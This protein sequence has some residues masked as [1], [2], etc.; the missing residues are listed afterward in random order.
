MA[1]ASAPA[2]GAAD[3]LALL[4]EAPLPPPVSWMPQTWGWA[5]VGLLLLAALGWLA[6]LLVQRH[7]ANRYRRAAL[8]ELDTI[9]A[10]LGVASAHAAALAALPAL[11]KRTALAFAPR[12][13]V[14]SLSGDDWLRWLDATWRDGHFTRGPGRLLA[15]LAYTQ[16]RATERDVQALVALLRSWIAHHHAHV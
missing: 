11:A 9:E 15:T 10:D 1:A 13:A 8:C 16:E 3:P 4:Q 6:M 5:V 12:E 7:R 14:A 2:G